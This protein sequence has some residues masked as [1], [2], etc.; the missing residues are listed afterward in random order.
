MKWP[1][2]VYYENSD[3]CTSI[4]GDSKTKL[5]R[6]PLRHIIGTLNERKKHIVDAFK[7]EINIQ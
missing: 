5:G 1:V 2:S 7:T 6:N 3:A 4:V